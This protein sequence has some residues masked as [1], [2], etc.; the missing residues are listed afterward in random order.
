MPVKENVDNNNIKAE[1]TEESDY[2]E[3]TRIS[4]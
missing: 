4:S 3:P 1:L 2:N